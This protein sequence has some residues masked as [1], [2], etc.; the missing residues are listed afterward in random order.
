MT[1]VMIAS[2]ALMLL[3]VIAGA[4]WLAFPVREA[5]C[6]E[7]PVL[8]PESPAFDFGD[9]DPC[10]LSSMRRHPSAQ[11]RSWNDL[12]PAPAAAVPTPEL[13]AR[14]RVVFATVDDGRLV[15]DCVLAD[16]D[17]PGGHPEAGLPFTLTLG[18]LETPWLAVHVEAKLERWADGERGVD[19]E[20]L[21][22]PI[23][24]RATLVSA[25]SRLVL[26][27]TTVAGL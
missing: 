9:L 20:L 26:P 3:A 25:S 16:S 1:L 14:A 13:H 27:V 22:S 23:G 8:D 12:A 15:L 11:G 6:A 19:L 17:V 24:A 18:A 2:V 10:M 5:A 21:D 7:E 4:I